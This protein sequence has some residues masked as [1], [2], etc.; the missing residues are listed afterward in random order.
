MFKN[1]LLIFSFLI[2]GNFCFGLEQT[3]IIEFR[4]GV[5]YWKP[6][7]VPFE[8]REH[9][10]QLLGQELLRKYGIEELADAVVLAC[11]RG[12]LVYAKG[13]VDEI[14][15]AGGS[16]S[17][18]LVICRK[19]PLPD[20]DEYGVGAVTEQGEAIFIDRLVQRHHLDLQSEIMKQKVETT[21]KE[22]QRRVESYR[23]NRPPVSI[24]E[25]VVILVDGISNG[26]TMI[27]CV[28]SART[29]SKAPPRRIIVATPVASF[30]GKKTVIDLANIPEE[31]FC[32]AALATPP[33]KVL[34][35]SDDFYQK[36]NLF[37]QMTD[38]DVRE[39]LQNY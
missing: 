24:K 10:G 27:A 5:S 36:T 30:K 29:R 7:P 12:G 21:Q 9:A 25:K 3:G 16:P 33:E 22:V 13:I 26:G 1:L 2:L 19:I 15:N 17:L 18:D 6:N 31:D 39:I 35:N 23:Q 37:V 4:E 34:W 20:N 14:R 11:P 8:S 38:Q 32:M 28:A